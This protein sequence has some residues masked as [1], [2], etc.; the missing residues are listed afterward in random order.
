MS[1][2]SSPKTLVV[3]GCPE[4]VDAQW[5]LRELDQAPVLV[6]A[7][8]DKRLTALQRA[9]TILAPDVGQLVFPGWDCLP[10]DRI[11]PNADISA[12]RMATLAGL[13]HGMP[14]RFVLL[15]TLNAA[16]QRVPAREVLKE[17]AFTADLGQR[18]DEAALK[19]FLVRMGFSQAP[20][21]M[22]PG[23]Y[24]VRGGIIDI[25]PPGEGGRSPWRN[26]THAA[27]PCVC[28]PVRALCRAW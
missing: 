19:A 1:D 2:K 15:T 17:A 28:G 23:D 22:E 10:Y 4:G 3:G 9:L 27:C 26:Q 20:T 14:S 21:V 25:Y 11:S 18:I 8:D 7:R 16:T 5:I 13:V 24:A 12:A 6:V